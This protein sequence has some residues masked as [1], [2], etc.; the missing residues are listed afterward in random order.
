MEIK[1]VNIKDKIYPALLKELLDAPK[2]LYFRGQ[3]PASPSASLGGPQKDEVCLAMVGTRRYSE[4]GKRAAIFLAESLAR[5]GITIVSGLAI[6]I[7]AFAHQGALNVGGRTIAVL[8]SGVDDDSIYPAQNKKLAQKILENNGALISEYPTGT[9]PM[10]HH[11]PLRNRII[12]GLCKGV[13]II[14]ARE[15]SGALITTAR[16]LEQNR[17]VFALPGPIF[18]PTSFGPNNLIKLGAKLITGVNDILEELNLPL[19]ETE[20]IKIKPA[21]QEEEKILNFLSQEPQS[22]NDLTKKTKLDIAIINSTLTLLEIKGAV[23]NLGKGN[24]ILL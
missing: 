14:E 3:L 7:D 13:I 22:I 21:N 20:K 5:L 9:K 11:F 15:K 10:L 12:S 4:Y 18:S 8:G 23:K 6:G 2:D 1:K 24:Y 16:A 19:I 17:E